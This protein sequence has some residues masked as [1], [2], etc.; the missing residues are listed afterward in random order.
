LKEV[1]ICPSG[2]RCLVLVAL[3]LLFLGAVQEGCGTDLQW[4]MRRKSEMRSERSSSD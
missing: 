4:G 3:V 2:R 1:T